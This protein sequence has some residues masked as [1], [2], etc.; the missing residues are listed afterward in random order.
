MRTLLTACHT[1]RRVAARLKSDDEA[2]RLKAT[3]ALSLGVWN[4]GGADDYYLDE[5]GRFQRDRNEA[6]D[7]ARVK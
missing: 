3:W 1:R 4:S 6:S 7:E 5:L 2:R